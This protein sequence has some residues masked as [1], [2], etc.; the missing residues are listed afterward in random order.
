M[1][2]DLYGF[3]LLFKTFQ[4]Q[5]DAGMSLRNMYGNNIH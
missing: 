4:S 2:Q 1:A 5:K 3:W